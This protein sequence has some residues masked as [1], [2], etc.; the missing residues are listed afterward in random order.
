M[1][2]TITIADN[3]LFLRDHRP[4]AISYDS[5]PCMC[6]QRAEDGADPDCGFCGGTGS[7]RF[8]VL[9]FEINVANGNMRT[10]WNALGLEPG[11]YL[12]GSIPAGD[13]LLALD[14]ADA[15]LIVRAERGQDA[16]PGPKI[17]HCGIVPRQAKSYLTALRKIAHEADDRCEEVTWA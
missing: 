3:A 4:E 5:Y 11:E 14:A 13:L 9:P 1:S 16:G 8:E 12:T 17:I 6:L 7:E 15:D 2:V 10:L